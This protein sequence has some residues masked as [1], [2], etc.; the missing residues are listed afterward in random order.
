MTAV[1]NRQIRLAAHP[2]GFPSETDFSRV[3]TP[4][5][6]PADGRM[7]CRTIYLS[8]DPYMRGRM[9]PGPSYARGVDLGDVMVGGTV[10]QVVESRL[11]GYAEG[12]IVLTANGWQ[13]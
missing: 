7:L 11:D 13:D 6:E 12:D 5:P 4:V 1:E 3:Q 9:N 8:L 2:A 10:S